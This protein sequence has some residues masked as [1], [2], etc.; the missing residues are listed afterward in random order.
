MSE[1]PNEK[2]FAMNIEISPPV[3]DSGVRGSVYSRLKR[4]AGANSSSGTF[5]IF[6]TAVFSVPLEMAM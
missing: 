4:V 6:T 2:A 1:S 3:F 5:V